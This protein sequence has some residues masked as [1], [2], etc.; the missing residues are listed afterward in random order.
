MQEGWSTRKITFLLYVI[1][2]LF[3]FSFFFIHHSFES[4][5]NSTEA[6]RSVG[7]TGTEIQR[8]GVVFLTKHVADADTAA[9]VDEGLSAFRGWMQSASG[10]DE[11]LEKSFSSVHMCWD[12]LKNAVRSGN[13]PD[14]IGN[15]SYECSVSQS[16]LSLIAGKVILMEKRKAEN[17]LY[18]E[19]ALMMILTL[20]VI[21]FVRVYIHLQEKKHSIYDIETKLFNKLYFDAELG[22]HWT[23]VE[24][25]AA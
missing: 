1:V 4:V 6:L 17:I 23:S 12:D 3:S 16:T 15:L 22:K 20:F 11:A 9:A 5:K 14:V 2:L 25:D 13:D 19:S 21:Y 24:R 18:I 7:Q 8:Y 10:D